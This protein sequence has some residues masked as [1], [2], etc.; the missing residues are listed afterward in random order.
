VLPIASVLLAFVA[1]AILIL[2]QGKNPGLA[3]KA[4]FNGSMNGS[5]A[6]GR[7][8]DKA[9]P[10]IL[11]GVAVIVALK[12]GLFNI[13]AEGQLVMGSIM[14]AYVGYR[15][16]MPAIIHVPFAL[17]VGA[18]FGGLT[19]AIAGFLKATRNVHEVISTIMLNTIVANFTDYLAGGPWQMKNQAV[20]RTAPILKSA[21]IS[22]IADLPIGFFIAL[23]IAF[24]VWF[25]VNR[26]TSGFRMNTVGL[27][28][29]AAHY[30]GISV[31]RNTV[32]AMTLSGALA[33]LGG[34]LHIQGV[35]GYFDPNSGSGLGFDGITIALLARVSPRAA[36]PSALL[37]GALRA[38]NTKLQADALLAPEI[39]DGVLGIILLF[40]AAPIIVRWVLRMRKGEAGEQMQLT[41][42]WGA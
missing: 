17:I 33:G 30:A 11:T 42:G 21:K 10:L 5:E 6:I 38:S 28:K 18:I 4:I 9:T 31:T 37:I 32:L 40:V 27:N 39:I 24:A 34:A 13:G 15:F 23:A 20:T 1:G 36:I 7:T 29:N 14:A 26:T 19:A 41:K 3:A 8:F 2:I 35:V 16:K 12:A 25:L 22:H